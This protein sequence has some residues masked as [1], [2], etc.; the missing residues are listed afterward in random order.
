MKV[1]S[2]GEVKKP[3]F[4]CI[5]AQRSG[6]TWFFGQLR[7]HPA[8][9]MPFRKEL[10]YFDRDPGYPSPNLFSKK[11]FIGRLPDPDFRK[12]LVDEISKSLRKR[13]VARLKWFIKYYCSTVSDRW[14]LSLFD[15]LQG[16]TGDLTPSYAILDRTDIAKIHR[17]LPG[18]RILFLIRDP[19]QRALS[20]YRFT[21]SRR[22]SISTDAVEIMG[23]M[24]SPL[25]MTRGN[26]LSTIENYLSVFGTGRLFLGFYDAIAEQPLNLLNGFCE[27]MGTASVTTNLQGLGDQVNKSPD[28]FIPEAVQR[29]LIEKYHRDI[30]KLATT[31]GGYCNAWY[32]RY[33]GQPETAGDHTESSPFLIL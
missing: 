28:L 20:A 18:V 12:G 22:T 13:N 26:Y 11:T 17:L 33:Y 32:T 5:G 21:R 2:H 1:R 23:F 6:T 3:Q 29:H 14:Y 31:F 7:E 24:E 15:G 8:F 27:F 30:E 19:V 10:H 25:Q 16:L 9:S 4:I